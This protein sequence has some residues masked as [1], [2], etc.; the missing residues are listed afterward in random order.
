MADIYLILLVWDIREMTIPAVVKKILKIKTHA[1]EE[2]HAIYATNMIFGLAQSLL[3]IFIPIY[4]FNLSQDYILFSN[5]QI[6]N[7]FV[8]VT[9]Y[10]AIGSLIVILSILIFH[11]LIFDWTLKKT[12]F[13]SKLFLIASYACLSLSEHTIYLVFLAA[14]FGGIHTTFYWIPYHIF[15]V[16]RAD[17]GDKKYGTET[18]RRDFLSGLAST[19]GPLLGALMISQLGFSILYAFAIFLLLV[20]TL[21]ILIF[22]KETSHRK[23]SLKDVCGS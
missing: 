11:K 5:D 4:I 23:H 3:G 9:S 16:K 18:G 1:V 20:A 12:I 7:G 19:L 15:F 14:F 22:V 8:W 2:S 21:P 6:I 13:Y 17:D 10:Y